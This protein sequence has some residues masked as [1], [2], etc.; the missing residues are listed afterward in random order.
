MGDF[1]EKYI[2]PGGELTHIGNVLTQMG[3][4]GLE[5]VD[6]ENLRPHYARTLWAWS[7]SLESRLGEAS[8]V[9]DSTQGQ[10]ALRA[11]RLYLAG[12][13]AGFENGW[14]ALYQIVGQHLP[15]RARADELDLPKD[16]AYP[17]R[18]DYMYDSRG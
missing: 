4:A 18:R 5:S 2:F 14:I 3:N 6:V 16:L 9:L 17:W 1:I 11:Y 15:R 12:C 10:R 7:D 8:K 13:A